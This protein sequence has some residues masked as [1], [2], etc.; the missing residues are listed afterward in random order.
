[1]IKPSGTQPE[2]KGSSEW[3]AI[4]TNEVEGYMPGTKR[5]A[6][7]PLFHREPACNLE[8]RA[9]K[10]RDE[11]LRTKLAQGDVDEEHVAKESH[12]NIPLV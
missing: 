4:R 7:G 11:H 8:D 5:E 9:T 2:Q 12:E 3:A 10:L 1:L 6:N